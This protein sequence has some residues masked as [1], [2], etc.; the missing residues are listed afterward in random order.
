[1]ASSADRKSVVTTE[2]QNSLNCWK[3]VMSELCET[4]RTNAEKNAARRSSKTWCR[5][6][7]FKRWRPRIC[8][9]RRQTPHL[10]PVLVAVVSNQ[11]VAILSWRFHSLITFKILE[12]VVSALSSATGA[13]SSL[14]TPIL[15]TRIGKRSTTF[16]F[17]SDG[18][19][20]PSQWTIRRTVR[21][22][23][24]LI[25]AAFVSRWG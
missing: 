15:E 16:Q 12:A 2:G 5:Q 7:R 11:S 21:E 4:S 24:S 14:Q 23:D 6:A 20:F 3:N 10:G 9:S 1:M 8:C 19:N 22:N 17:V 13:A 18:I 25:S